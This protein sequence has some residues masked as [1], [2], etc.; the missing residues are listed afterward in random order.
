[1]NNKSLLNKS[2]IPECS[3]DV[4]AKYTAKSIKIN[5]RMDNEAWVDA[6]AYS[7]Q[8]PSKSLN[9]D[10]TIQEPGEVKLLWDDNYLYVGAQLDD[11]DVVNE[12]TEDQ[13]HLY[14]TGDLIEVFLK[15]A[16]ENYYW[17]VYGTPNNKKSWFFFP[18]RGRIIFPACANYLPPGLNVAATIAGTFNNWRERD[19]G[20][21]TEI[22]I[23]IKELTVHGAKFDNSCNWTVLIARYNYSA[24][25][26]KPELSSYPQLS[27]VN[28]HLYEEYARLKLVK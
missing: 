11:S 19:I 7:L 6:P 22:A 28:F 12:G 14:K 16:G 10:N 1:M 9:S 13:T 18:S 25:L 24:Y 26:E 27:A 20:W 21:T 5:G 4:V 23:P 3:N 15:P 8:L 17:E 2:A